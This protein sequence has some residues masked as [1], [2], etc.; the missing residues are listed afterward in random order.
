MGHEG[1]GEVIDVAESG[2]VEVGGRDF[3]GLS[4]R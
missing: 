1:V 4:M 2:S 3:T